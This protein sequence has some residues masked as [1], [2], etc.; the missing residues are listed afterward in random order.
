M[1]VSYARKRPFA[2]HR[3]DESNR[4]FPDILFDARNRDSYN[5]GFAKDT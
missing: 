2:S 3:S 1:A 4:L 5:A